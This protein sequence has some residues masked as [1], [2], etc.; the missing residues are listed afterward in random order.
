MRWYK[1]TVLEITRAGCTRGVWG[2]LSELGLIPWDQYKNQALY[3]FWLKRHYPVQF[4]Y[5]SSWFSG[6]QPSSEG[7]MQTPRVPF[8]LCGHFRRNDRVP[9]KNSQREIFFDT[10]FFG[11]KYV[12][13]HS[14]S[15]LKKKLQKFWSKIFTMWPFWSKNGRVPEKNFQWEIFV[16]STFSV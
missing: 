13:K 9:E 15:I 5:F 16:K 4:W 6:L 7:R 2:R 14:E 1:I 10:N 11:L 8:S 3:Y 12:L